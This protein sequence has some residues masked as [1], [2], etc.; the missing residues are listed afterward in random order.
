MD[1]LIIAYFDSA[2]CILCEKC[3]SIW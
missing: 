1:M 2:K 3:Y